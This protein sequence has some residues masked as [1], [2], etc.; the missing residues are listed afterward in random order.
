M[1]SESLTATTSTTVTL[2]TPNDN[3]LKLDFLYGTVQFDA[4]LTLV[5]P[6]G[7]SSV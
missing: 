3:T 2:V 7:K 6:E 4:Y 5:A 1:Y